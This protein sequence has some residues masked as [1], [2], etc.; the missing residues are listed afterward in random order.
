MWAASLALLAAPVA[1][2]AASA[3]T[4]KPVIV[5]SIASI[6]ENLDDIGYITK[7]AGAEDAGK[8]ARF[9]GNAFTNGLDKTKPIGMYVVPQAGDFHA[10]VFV[11]V[12]D[13]KLVLGTFKEQLGEPRDAGDGVLE[14]G[15]KQSA[16]I[17][18]QNGWAFIA[19]SKEQLTNLP[20]DPQKLLGKLPEQY[21]VAV[22]VLMQN[23][24]P[25]LR[26][27][28]A[29][30][31]KV[32]FKR[33][34][35]ARGG[36]Q[37]ELYNQL[38]SNVN[39]SLSQL[40][41]EVEEFSIGYAINADTK[42]TYVDINQIAVDGSKLAKQLAMVSDSKSAF[43]GFLLPD[44][45]ATFNTRARFGP[46][47]IKKTVAMLE[48]AREQ[49]HKKIDDN[50]EL[51]AEK[52]GPA[53][54]VADM[55]VDVAKKTI[56]SG[57]TDAGA[58]LLLEPKSIRFAAGGYVADGKAI[59]NAIKKLVDIA[60]DQPDFPEVKLNAG[61]HAGVTFHRITAPIPE[62]ESEAKEL[63][64][65]KLEITL[66]TGP[67]SAYLAFGKD[68][69]A[70]LKRVIDQSA[71]DADKVLPPGQFTISLLPILKFAESVDDNPDVH[72]LISTL[73]K[74]QSDKISIIS[75]AVP[76]GAMTRFQ[77][78]SGVV[79]VIGD[80]VQKFAS[81]LQGLQGL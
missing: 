16:F 70:L 74:A 41:D 37:P 75:H 44:A 24:P 81:A 22:K 5:V 61:S 45:S 64:G 73:E 11:P 17:K 49:L 12:K 13:L 77:V 9:F 15:D 1:Q 32:G 38:N 35:E 76:R 34:I 66:G 7:A 71:S 79:Q 46:D 48:G 29:D 72:E 3:Q 63:L 51:P 23:V 31:I 50:P 57:K 18:E 53:K 52:R 33:A 62:S 30:E 80:A 20:Q 47:E 10:V 59:E 67:Q 58:V 56:E 25:E 65:D 69:E 68:S 60:K 26:Q 19:Q 21:N 6:E 4:V 27:L 14:V 36:D 28:A 40:F 78:D 8:T 2:Q 54:E 43:A 55:F 42:A 39:D